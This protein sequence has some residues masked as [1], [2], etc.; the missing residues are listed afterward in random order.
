[1]N[2]QFVRGKVFRRSLKIKGGKKY[3][4][5]AQLQQKTEFRYRKSILYIED[6]FLL[7]KFK[8]REN[9]CIRFDLYMEGIDPCME[10]IDP[11]DIE[12]VLGKEFE[13][14]SILVV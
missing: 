10:R 4:F 8:E 2:C 11:Q 1:M 14:G 3:D 9:M 5:H 7:P 6:R 12:F 13:Q